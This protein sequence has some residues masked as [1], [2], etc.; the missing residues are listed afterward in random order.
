MKVKFCHLHWLVILHSDFQTFLSVWFPVYASNT[1]GLIQ[2]ASEI[3]IIQ[4][5]HC[6]LRTVKIS[7]HSFVLA[8]Q[9]WREQPF[10]PPGKALKAMTLSRGQQTWISTSFFFYMYKLVIVRQQGEREMKN[11]QSRKVP[12]SSD[13]SKKGITADLH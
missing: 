5:L 7:V 2:I 6:S 10:L 12:F 11:R 13:I 4:I 8:R 9:M 1:A 3:W